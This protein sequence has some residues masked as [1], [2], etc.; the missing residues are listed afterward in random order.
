MTEPTYQASPSYNY[1]TQPYLNIEAHNPEHLKVSNNP[2]PHYNNT[3]DV[4]SPQVKRGLQM[5][6]LPL[7]AAGYD[8]LTGDNRCHL[9][10]IDANYYTLNNA[11]QF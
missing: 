6:R 7:I 3:M 2:I 11:Y 10:N 9:Q 4:N 1:A 8:T 5:Q